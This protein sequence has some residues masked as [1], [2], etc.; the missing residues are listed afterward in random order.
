M[1]NNIKRILTLITTTSGGGYAGQTRTFS[2]GALPLSQKYKK[3]I[4]LY[5]PPP[6]V[7]VVDCRV[8]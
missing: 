4:F 2:E 6:L 5:K 7:V 3:D 1:M 8:D